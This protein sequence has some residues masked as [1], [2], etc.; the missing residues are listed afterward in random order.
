MHGMI[1]FGSVLQMMNLQG[2]GPDDEGLGS[3]GC[4]I[5]GGKGVLILIAMMI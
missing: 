2:W 3:D 4:E 5:P 1:P